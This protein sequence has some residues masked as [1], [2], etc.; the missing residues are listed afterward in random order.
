[1]LLGKQCKVGDQDSKDLTFYRGII[2]SE[3]ELGRGGNFRVLVM[4]KGELRTADTS[5]IYDIEDA[6]EV[7]EARACCCILN[8]GTC[9]C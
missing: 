7:A 5:Y 2:V 3:P 4:T 9:N 1:M 6:R 8:L